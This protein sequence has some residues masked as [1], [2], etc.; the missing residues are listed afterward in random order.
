MNL[1]LSIELQD[2]FRPSKL[3]SFHE[4]EVKGS[5][6]FESCLHST[7]GNVVEQFAQDL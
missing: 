5:L 2:L 6:H 3:M 4:L 1:C 7:D